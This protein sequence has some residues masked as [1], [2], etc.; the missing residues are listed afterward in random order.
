MNISAGYRKGQTQ[1]MVHSFRLNGPW[2]TN[3]ESE[4]I[5]ILESN[6]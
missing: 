6:N 3:K 2:R 4:K 1:F 5:Q